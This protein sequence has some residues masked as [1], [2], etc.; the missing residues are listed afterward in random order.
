MEAT[1]RSILARTP[2]HARPRRY[3]ALLLLGALLLAGTGAHTQAAA[4]TTVSEV[5]CGILLPG[6]LPEGQV[7]STTGLLTIT[8]AGTATLVCRGNLDPALAPDSTLIITDTPCALGDGGTVGE[9]HTQVSP[10]G[11]VLLV[12][13]NNPGTE[14][15]PPPDGD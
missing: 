3:A 5:E 6:I 7:L 14:P 11:Q 8:A 2:R 15:L 13:Q 10:S 4:S 9:S 1:P 12:C